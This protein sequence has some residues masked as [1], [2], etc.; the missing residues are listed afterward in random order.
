MTK[1][2]VGFMF[3]C[4][5]SQV[6]LIQKNKPQF[7]AGK[8]NGVGGKIEGLETPQQ[9]MAREFEEE[10]GLHT[11]PREWDQF[12]TLTDHETFHVTCFTTVRDML[13]VKTMEDEEVFVVAIQDLRKLRT[14]TDVPW[15]VA[16]AVDRLVGDPKPLYVNAV[17]LKP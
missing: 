14:L 5:L 9:A 6:V 7:Q 12:A 2:V 8:L 11:D 4:L 15:L 16:L 3:D 17:Y 1:Y 10:A 13:N